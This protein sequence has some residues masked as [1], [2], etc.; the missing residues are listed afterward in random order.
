MGRKKTDMSPEQVIEHAID[1]F[2][3]N[4]KVLLGINDSNIKLHEVAISHRIA[5]Y[6]EETLYDLIKSEGMSVDLEYN[7]H[8]IH[9]KRLPNGQVFRGLR[10]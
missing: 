9:E 8:E 4:D 3:Q 2:H 1:L 6:I 10:V 5:V 7:K